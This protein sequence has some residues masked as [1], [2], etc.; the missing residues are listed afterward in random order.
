M[1]MSDKIF[2]LPSGSFLAW[3]SLLDKVEGII[4]RSSKVNGTA[5]LTLWANRGGGKTMA[6]HWLAHELGAKPGFH[7]VGAWDLRTMPFEEVSVL[8]KS[9]VEA[10]APRTRH[11][12]LLDN[13][14]SLLLEDADHFT[15]LEEIVKAS[16][17]RGNITFITTSSVKQLEWQDYAVRERQGA[18]HIPALSEQDVVALADV[19][20]QGASQIA[21]LTLGYPIAVRW[22]LDLP[23]LN[24]TA[25]WEKIQQYFNTNLSDKAAELAEVASLLPLFNV[26]VLRL[27]FVDEGIATESLYADYLERLREL[28]TVGLVEWDDDAKCYRFADGVVRRLLA[29]SFEQRRPNAYQRIQDIALRYFQ[30]EARRISDLSYS[31]LSVLYHLAQ[32]Q[33]VS[34]SAQPGEDCLQWV[35]N[36]RSSWNGADWRT[37]QETWKSGAND[38][39]LVE[40]FQTLLGE[41]TYQQITRLLTTVT[42]TLEAKP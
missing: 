40:E 14:D 34:G 9:G 23:G 6:L 5:V 4:R 41:T 7:V 8:I 27:M 2:P 10:A 16:L 13:L 12:I 17:T 28:A 42:Q 1:M 39:V 30:S 11:V 33:R 24:K 20:G 19:S 18:F 38:A 32:I 21:A 35:Y 25:Y 22:L 29:S 37:I 31:L 15:R 36:N 26:A 3:Q